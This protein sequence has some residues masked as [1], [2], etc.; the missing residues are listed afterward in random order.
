MNKTS[1]IV[2]YISF[3]VIILLL[4]LLVVFLINRDIF[5]LK[6]RINESDIV[7]DVEIYKEDT[8]KK[9]ESENSEKILKE[10]F[11]SGKTTYISSN[12]DY[13]NNA[14]DVIRVSIK[15]N[16]SVDTVYVYKR[17]NNYYIESPY[18][19]IYKISKEEYN[20]INDYLK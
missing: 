20:K 14:L 7:T 9:L 12:Y 4:V 2:I 8:S 10:I 16:N 13:P 1:K 18:N 15:S 11:E 19:G 17:K 5:E 3:F 6:L